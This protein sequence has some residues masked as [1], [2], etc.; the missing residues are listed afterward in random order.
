[1]GCENGSVPFASMRPFWDD[2][3]HMLNATNPDDSTALINTDIEHDEQL[4]FSTL[5]NK[6]PAPAYA[7]LAARLE[8]V[9]SE[10]FTSQDAGHV[11]HS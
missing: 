6:S 9:D 10:G 7:R 3:K 2:L 11:T 4:E 8:D 5:G 1:M